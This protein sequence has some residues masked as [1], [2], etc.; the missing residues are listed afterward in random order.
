MGCGAARYRQRGVEPEMVGWQY[1]L[2][3]PVLVVGMRAAANE[4]FLGTI[5]FFIAA[6]LAV[7][8]FFVSNAAGT[9]IRFTVIRSCMVV[10]NL[11]GCHSQSKKQ[12]R[13]A[14]R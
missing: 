3:I 13:Y 7:C 6:V 5:S 2:P 14:F 9:R 4:P 10:I 12:N 1:R 11:I 8:V